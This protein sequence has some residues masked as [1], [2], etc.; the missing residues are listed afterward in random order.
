MEPGMIILSASGWLFRDI[1]I[2]RNYRN[3]FYAGM[4][5]LVFLATYLAIKLRFKK[6]A[7]LLWISS[8][9]ICLIWEVILFATGARDY[10]FG[11]SQLELFY[12]AL[13]EAG[14][15]LIIMII[16]AHYI[17]LIDISKLRDDGG[18]NG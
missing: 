10:H 11:T 4:F 14:P 1:G 16:F 15:G 9:S 6:L 7:A 12:H 17:K 8:G 18:T 5:V 2:Y 13:T 3:I